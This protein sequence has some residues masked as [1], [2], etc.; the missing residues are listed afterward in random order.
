VGIDKLS[1]PKFIV[2]F[3][4]CVFFLN[5]ISIFYMDRANNQLNDNLEFY[6]PI[7]V[8][9]VIASLVTFYTQNVEGRKLL[10]AS[11]GFAIGAPIVFFAHVAYSL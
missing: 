11:L 2:T 9:L 6:A 7:I 3:I 8:A 10:W 5:V 1:A 4:Y